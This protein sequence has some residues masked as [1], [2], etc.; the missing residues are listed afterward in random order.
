MDKIGLIVK[1]FMK[2]GISFNGSIVKYD[3]SIVLKLVSGNILE[4]LSKDE[5]VAIE[6]YNNAKEKNIDDPKPTPKAGDTQS[7]VALRKLKAEEELKDIKSK[8]TS[9]S[10]SMEPI[11]YES[12]LSSLIGI[13]KHK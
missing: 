5:I 13:I 9:S 8:L 12:Q 7:L 3:E 1:V 2:N 4:I 6:Y 10:I 11:T